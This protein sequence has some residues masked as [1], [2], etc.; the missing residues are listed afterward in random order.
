M[1]A[2][3]IVPAL[4]TKFTKQAEL[5]T[6]MLI[7]NAKVDTANKPDV[8]VEY[9]FYVKQ[10]GAGEVFQQDQSAGA[11]RTDAAAGFRFCCRSPTAERSG[12]PPRV[13]PRGRLPARDQG[14]RQAG[15]Q[16]ADA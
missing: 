5:S 9:N 15:E 2:M 13:V 12:R 16:D 7:Y 8:T 4:T 11:E 3:E 14:D 1:G 6:F 10:A